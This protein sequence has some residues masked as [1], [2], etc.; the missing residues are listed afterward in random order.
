M[1]NGLTRSI[2]V[3]VA[4]LSVSNY[5]AFLAA[6]K[7]ETAEDA[8]EL[9]TASVTA[10]FPSAVASFL[11]ASTAPNS[12][13]ECLQAML[14]TIVNSRRGTLFPRF[15]HAPRFQ[16]K[17]QFFLPS[18]RCPNSSCPECRNPFR[19]LL[20]SPRRVAAH[21]CPAAYT[22]GVASAVCF[23]IYFL[24]KLLISARMTSHS[25]ASPLLVQAHSEDCSANP[26]RVSLKGANP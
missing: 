18:L 25:L 21:P 17:H 20:L 2:H 3:L 15:L 26:P 24:Y 1:V 10:A 7:C 6:T 13:R 11:T 19:T 8:R 16:I 4:S 14:R 23:P 9:D 5:T 22:L 12:Q